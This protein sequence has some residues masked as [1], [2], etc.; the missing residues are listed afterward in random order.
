MLAL[1]QH[2]PLS[3]KELGR[4]RQL[5]PAT[6]SPL[7]KRLEASGYV[8]RPRARTDER[9]LAVTL[10][11]AGWRLRQ[12]AEKIPAAIVGRLG[13]EV[14]ELQ[15]LHKVLTRVISA[16]NEANGVHR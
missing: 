7:L 8:D 15:D 1:W 10:T 2:A 14:S 9:S 12:E 11:P 4:L 5:E 13:M 3:V 16:A 6:L